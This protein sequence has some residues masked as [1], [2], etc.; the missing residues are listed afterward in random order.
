MAAGLGNVDLASIAI[1]STQV[2]ENDDWDEGATIRTFSQVPTSDTPVDRE[3]EQAPSKHTTIK[4]WA[5]GSLTTSI[6]ELVGLPPKPLKNGKLRH[7][8]EDLGPAPARWPC[9]I[10]LIHPT[11]G[12][13]S[14][15]IVHSH[16][17]YHHEENAGQRIYRDP[18][19][20]PEVLDEWGLPPSAQ[21]PRSTQGTT[22]SKTQVIRE[23]D[24]E[25]YESTSSIV[26]PGTLCD[27]CKAGKAGQT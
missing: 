16:I 20:E 27:G 2:I 10:T 17:C 19:L 3:T 9:K 7:V 13:T 8:P 12:H 11:C 6:R 21:Q 1:G 26:L 5:S 14:R 25:C 24:E 15:T 22:Q 4:S 18:S 23:D